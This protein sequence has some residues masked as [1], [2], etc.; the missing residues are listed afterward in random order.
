LDELQNRL[1]HLPAA[2]LTAQAFQG[3]KSHMHT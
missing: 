2:A 3:G 1:A